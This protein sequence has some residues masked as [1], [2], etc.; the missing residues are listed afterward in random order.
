MASTLFMIHGM[1]GGPWCFDE[2]RSFLEARGHRCVVAALPYHDVDPHAPPDPHLGTT[3]LLDYAKALEQ[4]IRALDVRPI[5]VGHSLGGLLAQMLG[6]RGLAEALVLLA[7][8][9]P[10]GIFAVRPSVVWAFRSILTTWAS[11]RKPIRQ[12]F[13]EAVYSAFHLVPESARHAIFDRFVAESGRVAFEV[14]EWMFD[15]C[16]ASRVDERKVTCPVLV[17]VGTE[18]RMTPVGVVRRVAQKYAP[19]VTYREFADHAHWLV[20]E[21]GWGEIAEYVDAWLRLLPEGRTASVSDAI[22]NT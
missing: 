6:S 22:H 7:P 15:A 1:W 19:V 21:P 10:A 20:G 14:G 11:W 8:A 2:Y 18:D 5:L 4:E 9:A 3:S 16:G 17:I 13:D 12:T